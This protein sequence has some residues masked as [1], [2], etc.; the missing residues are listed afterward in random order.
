MEHQY[1]AKNI[2]QTREFFYLTVIIYILVVGGFLFSKIGHD[3]KF[4]IT[5]KKM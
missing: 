4:I 1:K 2:V 3:L 5:F